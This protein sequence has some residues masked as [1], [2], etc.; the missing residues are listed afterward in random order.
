[1]SGIAAEFAAESTLLRATSRL[2]EAGMTRLEAYTP[3]PVEALDDLLPRPRIALPTLVFSAGIFGLAAGFFMQW[4]GAAVS[5]PLNIGGRPLASWPAFIPIAFE[6][7][8]LCTVASGFI[9]F[10]AL[11]RLPRPYQPIA[12]L[13]GFERAKGRRAAARDPVRDDSSRSP[14][15]GMASSRCRMISVDHQRPVRQNFTEF[16]NCLPVFSAE[17]MQ[18]AACCC[19][20]PA[21]NPIASPFSGCFLE[22]FRG[23][24]SVMAR[25][26]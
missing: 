8:V 23:C 26:L 7:A 5:Y 17:S 12:A 14:H 18:D 11:A 21:I 13:P 9:G 6:I 22:R 15:L 4:Y 19:S 25:R 24:A 16:D 2:R 3:Y 20:W 1:M 10:F